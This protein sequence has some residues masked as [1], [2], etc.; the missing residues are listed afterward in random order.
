MLYH[1]QGVRHRVCDTS[2][3]ILDESAKEMAV[4]GQALKMPKAAAQVEAPPSVRL[5]GKLY[6]SVSQSLP[7]PEA[8]SLSWKS[9][10]IWWSML[11]QYPGYQT[12]RYLPLY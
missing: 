10:G 12:W 4:K 6:S 8:L 9:C 11:L 2:I 5:D 7:S 3:F 1:I